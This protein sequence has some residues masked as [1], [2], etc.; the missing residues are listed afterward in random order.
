MGLVSC[1]LVPPS[2]WGPLSSYTTS[3]RNHPHH[4]H[5]I[6]YHNLCPCHRHCHHHGHCPLHPHQHGDGQVARVSTSTLAP[7]SFSLLVS[8]ATVGSASR[9]LSWWLY[10][11][12]D[13][14]FDDGYIWLLFSWFSTG[15]L[16]RF[17]AENVNIFFLEGWLQ[18]WPTRSADSCGPLVVL[19]LQALWAARY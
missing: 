17:H 1:L 18:W 9:W 6:H 12:F 19:R 7:R 11:D 10:D 3:V 13:Y 5:V 16:E 8:S 15:F 14:N 4:I 2:H